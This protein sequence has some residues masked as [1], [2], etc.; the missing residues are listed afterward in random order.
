M[1]QGFNFTLAANQEE[2]ITLNFSNSNPGGFTLEDVHPVDGNNASETDLFY[3]ASGVTETTGVPEPPTIVL[4]AM[5][6]V[7]LAGG[8][9]R[10]VANN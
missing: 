2:V 5:G 4:L 9:R 7:L 3:S 6:A 10:L 1:A 8:A